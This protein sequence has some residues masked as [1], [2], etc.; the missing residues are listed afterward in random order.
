MPKIAKSVKLLFQHFETMP[1]FYN[2]KQLADFLGISHQ[3]FYTCLKKWSLYYLQEMLIRFMVKQASEHL[4]PLLKKS[5]ATKSRAS[6]TISVDNSVIDRLG[7]MLRC[8]WSWYSGRCKKVINGND[9]LGIVLTISG[10]VFPLYL[11]FCSKQGRAHT[12]KPSLL[13]A[14]LTRLKDEFVKEDID[15]TAFPITLD[16][17]FVS[18]FLKQELHLLGFHKIIIAGKGNYTFTINGKKQKASEWKKEIPLSENQWGIDVPSCRIEAHSPTF[19]K[20]VL[21]FYKKSTTRNYYLMDFSKTLMRSAEIWHIWKQ[22]Y[23]IEC[24]WKT[25]KSTFKIKSMQ[26]Q[27]DGL[28][29][30]LLIK[31][32]SY[33]VAMRLKAQRA[34]SKL[35]I[36]QITRKIRREYDLETLMTEHFHLSILL[37]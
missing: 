11:L 33:L 9:L 15:L 25:L 5:E 21:F 4:K 16:S 1:G 2:P 28:Y 20:T 12:D 17:W 3:Q 19:G 35:T 23:L 32:I 14:M 36:T 6:V 37:T 10:I 18:E 30:G 26:L 31:V 22:H 8:T 34:F 24:F 7:R 13:I 29:A 27:G